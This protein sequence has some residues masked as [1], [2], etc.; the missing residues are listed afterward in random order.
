MPEIRI[1]GGSLRGRKIAVPSSD[2]RPTS[3]R[4]RQA[5]F[6]I[7]ADRIEGARFLEL[8]AGTAIFSFEAVSRGAAEATAVEQSARSCETINRT[9]NA[10]A[11]PVRALHGEVL[12]TLPRLGTQG[13][14]LV[15]ADPPYAF[16]RYPDLVHLLDTEA[17]LAPGG[18]AAVEHRRGPLPFDPDQLTSLHLWKTSA[19]SGVAITLLERG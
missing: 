7:I 19:Y 17:V 18:V 9:A 6:N 3:S 11:V 1:T 15:Y 13:F 14:D 8:F 12:Q 10:L 2:V 5:Y 16:E 4:A